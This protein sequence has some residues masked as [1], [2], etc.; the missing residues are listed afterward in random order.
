MRPS[1]GDAFIDSGQ[2]CDHL[3]GRSIRLGPLRGPN[4][5]TAWVRTIWIVLTGE[6]AARLVLI[7]EERP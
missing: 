3:V 7:P 5:A 4:G 2:A 6:K 1:A